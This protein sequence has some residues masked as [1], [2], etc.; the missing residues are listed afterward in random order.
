MMAWGYLLLRIW[1]GPNYAVNSVQYLRILVLANI[2]RHLCAPY[3]TMVVATAR[4][5]VATAA[6][7]TEAVVNLVASIW[8]A[9]HYGA[10]GVAAGTLVGSFTGVAMHFAISMHYTRNIDV[11]RI[12]LFIK[13]ILAPSHHG[14][15][16]DA[17]I[18]ALV[19]CRSAVD[20]HW[21]VD[22]LGRR[23]LADRV[24]GKPGWRRPQPPGSNRKPRMVNVRYRDPAMTN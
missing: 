17:L 7:I 1:V 4:Q 22:S 5:N 18:T 11:S 21:S 24:A 13:G 23:D 6:A 20:Q 9:R 10:M 2:I 19:V 3:S 14:D 12:N 8:L 16:V 15:S